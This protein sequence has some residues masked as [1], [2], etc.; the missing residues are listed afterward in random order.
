MTWAG[1]INQ[2]YR[3]CIAVS[4]LEIEKKPGLTPSHMG[5]SYK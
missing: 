4:M 1:K 2:R 3:A 5:K